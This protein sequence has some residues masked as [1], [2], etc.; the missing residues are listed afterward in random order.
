MLLDIG[1]CGV[2]FVNIASLLSNFGNIVQSIFIT[3]KLTQ[4]NELVQFP[5][6]T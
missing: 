1:D 5:I 6:G 2:A 4:N 3:D